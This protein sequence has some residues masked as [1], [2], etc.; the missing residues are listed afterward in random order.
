MISTESAKTSSSK[1]F[2]VVE[3]YETI[4]QL[5]SVIEGQLNKGLTGIDCLAAS[6]PPG[7]MTG[8]PKKR[9]CQL[10]QELEEYKPR[11]VYSGILGY[12]CVSGKGDFSVVIRSMYKWDKEAEEESAT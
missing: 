12:M 6:L 4:F 10:L 7:S 5:V 11:S 2:M 3:E 8:A 9:S 1:D